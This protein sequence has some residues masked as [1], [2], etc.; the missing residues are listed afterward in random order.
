MKGSL[1]GILMLLVFYI[2]DICYWLFIYWI[3]SIFGVLLLIGVVF[4]KDYK[5][6]GNVM[7]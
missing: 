7:F 5:M 6:S 3:L 4:D 1:F 2:L